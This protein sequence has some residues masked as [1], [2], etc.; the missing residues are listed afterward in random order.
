MLARKYVRFGHQTALAA[1][2]LSLDVACASGL[3]SPPDI[4]AD[5][6]PDSADNCLI[7]PNPVQ[8]D[9][10]L[11]GF[12]NACDGDFDNDGVVNFSDLVLMQR[13]FFSSSALHDLNSDDTVNLLDLVMIKKMFFRDP[14]PSGKRTA[15]IGDHC[16]T[17]RILCNEGTEEPLLVVTWNMLPNPDSLTA[18]PL[19]GMLPLTVTSKMPTTVFVD[20]EVAVALDEA[21][22]SLSLGTVPVQP[23]SSRTVLLDPADFS[24]DLTGLDFSGRLVARAKARLEPGGAV[25]R[26]AY[27]PHSFLHVDDG[28]LQFYRETRMLQEFNAGDYKRSVA[29]PRQWALKRGIRLVGIG[30]AGRLALSEDD[31]GPRGRQEQGRGY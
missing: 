21:R 9:T 2:M 26:M 4:D 24:T 15:C 29:V 5:G 27:T 8:R 17:L 1:A 20:V 11:D 12:G 10:D 19:D 13:N 31:G 14:G 28:K 25:E 23:F 7:V 3:T 6:V 18:A 22:R 16:D 30:H